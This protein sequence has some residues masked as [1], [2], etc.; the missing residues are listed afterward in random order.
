M[1]N[2]SRLHL[3]LALSVA[4]ILLL[5][6]QVTAAKKGP[7]RLF[8]NSASCGIFKFNDF[9]SPSFTLE[10]N[11][12]YGNF[13]VGAGLNL[14]S[15][16]RKPSSLD[17]IVLLSAL[18]DTGT[19]GVRYESIED[20]TYGQGLLVN[21]YSTLDKEPVVIS[22]RAA[23][24]R[25]YY[26]GD[27]FDVDA[28][29]TYS[30]LYG[31]RASEDIFGLFTFGQ[32]YLTDADGE[33]VVSRKGIP[34]TIDG[35]SGLSF[36]VWA[37][38]FGDFDLYAEAAEIV[39]AGGGY[40]VGCHWGYNVIF[41]YIN[42]RA[43]IRGAEPGFVPGYFGWAYET[44]PINLPSYEAYGKERVGYF[45]ELKGF[46]FGVLNVTVAAEG[47]NDSNGAFY[48][49]SSLRALQTLF[50]SAYVR[51]PTFVSY[52]YA[53]LDDGTVIGGSVRYDISPTM[54]VELKARKN[55]DPDVGEVDES[56]FVGF[57]SI[58]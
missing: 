22:N 2:K 16:E 30:H 45:A 51:Q 56:S 21:A 28:F 17:N 35:R 52:R 13:F 43:E 8:Y 32:T 31:I 37:P 27:F 41:A 55:F 49:D 14:F 24:L 26:L 34:D 50:V 9:Y 1:A 47:Y 39:N 40:C 36:D 20:L 3:A 11:F 12:D 54:F 19:E 6:A 18:W 53:G 58:F 48:L 38:V 33:K 25:A 5:P 15:A 7:G 44:D 4:F 57:G 29:A 23:G 46:I 10:N 42:G